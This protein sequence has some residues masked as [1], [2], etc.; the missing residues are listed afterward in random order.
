[1]SLL[2][3]ACHTPRPPHHSFEPHN[4]IWG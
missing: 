1:L 2:S 4:D 3:Y